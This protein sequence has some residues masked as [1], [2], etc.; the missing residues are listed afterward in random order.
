META[1]TGDVRAIN[2][3]LERM[4]CIV[5]I[6]WKSDDGEDELEEIKKEDEP[7]GQNE[8]EKSEDSENSDSFVVL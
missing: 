5:E 8:V 7:E 1:A 6:L 4:K 2:S 3:V